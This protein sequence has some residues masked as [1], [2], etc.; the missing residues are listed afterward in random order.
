M[1]SKTR[2]G[3][4]AQAGSGASAGG[5]APHYMEIL[6]AALSYAALGLPVFPCRRDKRPFTHHGFKDAATDAATIRD[7]WRRWPQ[8]L[9]GLP[10]GQSSG[11][12]V[13]DLDRKGDKDGEK[14]LVELG[15]D[16]GP[17]LRART[18]SGG[19]H[20][21]YRHPGGPLASG[22][23]LFKALLGRKET[24]IDIRADGGYVIAPP[25]ALADGRGWRFETGGLDAEALAHLPPWPEA[26]TA[27]LR[28]EQ[29]RRG[30]PAAD[31]DIEPPLPLGDDL[32]RLREALRSIPSDDRDAWLNVGM[33]IKTAHGERARA[34]WDEWS[35]SSAKFSAPDQDRTWRSLQGQGVTLGTVFWLAAQNGWRAHTGQATRPVSAAIPAPPTTQAPEPSK[36]EPFESHRRIGCYGESSSGV[37]RI[38]TARN[39]E[40]SEHLLANFSA[41]IVSQSIHDDGVEECRRFDLQASLCGRRRAFS[42][43]AA[44]FASLSWVFRELGAAAY[45]APGVAAR[46]QVRAAI[47]LF[48]GDDIPER[49]IFGHMGWREVEGERVYL[50]AGGAIGAGGAAPGVTTDFG[51]LGALRCAALPDPPTGERR[52]EAVRASLK[53]LDLGPRQI[54][55]LVSAAVWRSTFGAA[56]FAIWLS[57]VTGVFKSEVAALAQRHWGAGFHGKNLPGSWYSTANSNEAYAFAAKD[58][59]FA[60]DDFAP[61]GGRKDIDHLHR[62]AAR[63]LRGQGNAA[64]RARLNPDGSLRPAKPPRGLI[65]GTGEELPRGHSIRARCLLLELK[66][67]H[68]CPERLRAA[69][70]LGDAGVYAEAMAAWLQWL[71]ASQEPWDS[72]A[73]ERDQLRRPASSSEHARTPWMVAELLA[74]F[75]LFMAFAVETGALRDSEATVRHQECAA[76]IRAAA[77]AQAEHHVAENPARRFV[78]LMG[79]A[80]ATGRAALALDRDGCSPPQ[81]AAAMGWRR[82]GVFDWR[83]DGEL[84]GWTDGAVVWLEPTAAYGLAQKLAA[85][86]GAPLGVA[87]DTLWRRMGEAG[88]LALR[89]AGRNMHEK[90]IGGQKRKLVALQWPLNAQLADVAAPASTPGADVD[91]AGGFEF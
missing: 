9:I 58:A 84:I 89:S 66:R 6:D 50:H 56:D 12:A 91:D 46:D 73:A 85:Q 77:S 39:G 37:K 1:T 42:V 62:E 26:V 82:E 5:R 7:W 41:R 32:D 10:T 27:A 51:G 69:Q 74:A 11:L 83:R 8:A 31:P 90:K 57:G 15:V 81:D 3:A 35:R 18:A 54:M 47:Q 36:P 20:Y 23:D 43:R 70:L 78:E 4:K 29:S 63:L 45:I 38:V 30:A 59:V 2:D 67:G 24:G 14:A 16:P 64:G 75:K 60:V 13:L 34:L 44:D 53:L 86:E 55:A 40:E 71:A 19:S 22:A 49:R 80:L 72:F 65:F 52:A 88:L 68:I 28:R 33:A 76:A 61:E 79:A 87:K 48:S 17:S 21:Y 25:S